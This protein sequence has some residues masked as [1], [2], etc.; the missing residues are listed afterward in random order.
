MVN[1]MVKLIQWYTKTT[2]C[3]FSFQILIRRT[4]LA[5]IINHRQRPSR[6]KN[7]HSSSNSFVTSSMTMIW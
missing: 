2:F 1:N 6:I 4:L 3:A 5:I 7:N